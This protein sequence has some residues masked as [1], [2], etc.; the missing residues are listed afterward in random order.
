MK[1][2]K[3]K[4]VNID[5]EINPPR[6]VEGGGGGDSHM[7][8]SGMLLVSLRGVSQGF[9]SHLGCSKCVSAKQHKETTQMDI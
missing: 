9:W 1:F 5:W 2:E 6:E 3:L 4:V 8:K 7:E